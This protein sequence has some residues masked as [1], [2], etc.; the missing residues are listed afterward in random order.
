V[1]RVADDGRGIP[2]EDLGRIFELFVRGDGARSAGGEGGLGI[3]LALARSFTRLHGG[4]LTGRSE[5]PGRGSEFVVELP[6]AAPRERE[7]AAVHVP[8]GSPAARRILVVDDNTDAADLLADTL[9]AW[10]HVVAV[11]YDGPQ[12]LDVAGTFGADVAVLDIGMPVMDGYE[13]ARTLR[14][15]GHECRFVALTGYGQDHDRARSADAGFAA[16]LVKPVDL[17]A[18]RPLLAEGA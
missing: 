13:L 7:D 11:A 12:A 10:G 14:A 18:L 5:G 8:V 15:R 1:V 4:E 3:G 2:A 17:G 6:L 9:R 16:H